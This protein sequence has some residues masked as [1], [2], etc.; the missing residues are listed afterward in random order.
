MLHQIKKPLSSFPIT[1]QSKGVA[2]KALI[3]DATLAAPPNLFS[4]FSM[5]TIGMGASG[6]VYL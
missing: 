2:P 6:I 3:C 4:Y 5:S 1:E